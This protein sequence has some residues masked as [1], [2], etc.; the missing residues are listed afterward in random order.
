MQPNPYQTYGPDD[1]EG[2]EE[3]PYAGYGTHHSYYQPNY[4]EPRPVGP[5]E[6]IACQ[7]CRVMIFTV[8]KVFRNAKRVVLFLGG[9]SFSS[10]TPLSFSPGVRYLLFDP[11]PESCRTS[12]GDRE[13]ERDRLGGVVKETDISGH[14]KRKER[15][16][17]ELQEALS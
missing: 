17:G 16:A 3:D 2:G 11:I 6:P 12:D 15:E 9:R 10:R 7:A 14:G 4:P 13:G 8:T 5:E 1:V